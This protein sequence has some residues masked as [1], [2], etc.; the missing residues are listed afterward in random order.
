MRNSRW[1]WIEYFCQPRAGYLLI[2]P[3]AFERV[4]DGNAV[5]K[6]PLLGFAGRA[7]PAPS[8]AAA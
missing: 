8:R 1:Q 2:M 4:A 3:K 7:G 6:C 5:R